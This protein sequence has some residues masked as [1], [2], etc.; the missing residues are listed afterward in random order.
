[1]RH[2][3]ATG[4]RMLILAIGLCLSTGF[5]VVAAAEEQS[6]PSQIGA[7]LARGSANVVTGW[8]E[9]P[10]QIYLVGKK[11]GWVQGT[12]RGPLEGLGMFIARTVAGAYEVLTFPIP[13]PPRYQ[14]MLLPDYVWQEEPAEQLAVPTEPAAPMITPDNR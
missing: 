12:F 7:K 1:M 3:V 10:K 6:I 8:A 4:A 5:G 13:L 14:P 9:I 11:E 2:E